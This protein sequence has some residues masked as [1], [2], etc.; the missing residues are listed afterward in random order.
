MAMT[1][2]KENANACVPNAR[3][4]ELRTA[5]RVGASESES[6]DAMLLSLTGLT[7]Q[8]SCFM[9]GCHRV[10]RWLLNRSASLLE[11]PRWPQ[12]LCLSVRERGVICA[13]KNGIGR[14][15]RQLVEPMPCALRI[16]D[17]Q[18]RYPAP[19]TRS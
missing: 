13:R 15:F 8:K 10:P 3:T 7:A 16:T 11:A 6:C 9:T 1:F 18:C 14:L 19:G 2:P 5:R 4:T 17:C 12:C